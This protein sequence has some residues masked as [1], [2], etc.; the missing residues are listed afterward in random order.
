[1]PSK[2][3][4]TAAPN[5]QQPVAVDLFSGSGAVSAGL[6]PT[7]EIVAAVDNDLEACRTYRANHPKV[8]LFERDITRLTPKEIIL[9]VP[10]AKGA[11]LLVV[12]APCQP[13]SNQNRHKGGNDGRAGLVLQAAR[14][15]KALQPKLILFENVPGLVG[16]TG[17]HDELGEALTRVGYH[18]GRP[19]RL[20]AAD[21][22]VPQRRVRCVMFAARSPEAVERLT[23]ARFSAPASNVA[24]AI[25]HL[26]TLRSGETDPTDPMHHARVHSSIALRRLAAIPHD[27][28]SRDSLPAALRLR[29]HEGKKGYPD[30]YGRMSWSDV[31]PTLTTG[32]TDITRGRFAHPD[33]DRAI[34]VREAALLQ[35]FPP[36]YTFCGSLKAIARQI[37]NAVPPAMV[38]GMVPA[39]VD[40]LKAA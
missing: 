27:G 30:V 32:C 39:L 29:C 4:K 35:S 20:N 3:R 23:T 31:A 1:M 24:Q 34:T 16:T 10:R 5:K 12:C 40:A 9:A 33:Q 21:L 38:A 6:S 19:R 14:F 2:A 28:G 17:V 11:D 36:G 8:R 7:F 25:G 13:F 18:F 37:G 15:A 26:P 22:G